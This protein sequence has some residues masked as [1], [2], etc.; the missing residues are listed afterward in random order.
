ML[1]RYVNVFA[2]MFIKCLKMRALFGFRFFG[3]HPVH[4]NTL[5]IGKTGPSVFDYVSKIAITQ[6]FPNEF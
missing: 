2:Y 6:L 4:H 1:A 3:G 5:K